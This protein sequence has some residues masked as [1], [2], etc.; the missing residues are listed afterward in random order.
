SPAPATDRT[1]RQAAPE[2]SDRART[3]GRH[4]PSSQTS[5]QH[6]LARP[7]GADLPALVSLR[8]RP[9]NIILADWTAP[10]RTFELGVVDVTQRNSSRPGGAKVDGRRGRR[11]VAMAS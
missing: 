5:A 3:R 6:R 7:A 11:G 8:R 2:A 10:D 9:Q 4:P 1:R